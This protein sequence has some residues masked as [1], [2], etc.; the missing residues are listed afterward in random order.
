MSLALKLARR[1]LRGGLAGFR[2]FI[3]CLAL[4]VAVIAGVGSLSAGIDAA[5]QGDARALLGGDVDFHL[6]HRPASDAERAYLARAG[7]VSE[8][9]DMRAMART[10]DGGERS[11]IQLKAVDGNYPLYGEVALDPPQRLADALAFRDGHWGAVAEAGLFQRLGLKPGDLVRIGDGEFQLR[12]VLAHEPD[13]LSGVFELGPRVTLALPALPSTGL[14]RPG[15]LV[16]YSYRV[17]LEHGGDAAS[18]AARAKADLPDA[19]WRIRGFGEAAPS[20]QRLLDRLTV[21]LTLVGLTALLVGGVG[22]GN[23]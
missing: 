12:A 16:G 9:D 14:I 11:L 3:A 23:A 1:E 18:F 22:I 19:A 7:R 5:L 17:K 15:A 4:G 21:F 2:I 6:F 10:P 20:L 8:S 13:A